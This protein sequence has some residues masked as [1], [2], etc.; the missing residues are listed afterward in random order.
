[1]SNRVRVTHETRARRA[2][3]DFWK[4]FFIWAFIVLFAFSVA[5]GVIAIALVR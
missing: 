3:R 2:R 5:G 4:R 1:M